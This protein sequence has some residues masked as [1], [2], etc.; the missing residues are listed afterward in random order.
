MDAF[1]MDAARLSREEI[2]YDLLRQHRSRNEKPAGAESSLR[3]ADSLTPSEKS[4]S[5]AIPVGAAPADLSGVLSGDDFVTDDKSTKPKST[6]PRPALESEHELVDST[7]LPDGVTIVDDATRTVGSRFILWGPADDFIGQGWRTLEITLGL[8][9][10]VSIR[11]NWK[12]IDVARDTLLT[13]SCIV[14]I[15]ELKRTLKINPR[16]E[17]LDNPTWSE[18][19]DFRLGGIEQKTL[20]NRPYQIKWDTVTK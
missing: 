13:G 16:E 15:P 20:S 7:L 2:E 10:E 6:A 12:R 11:D 4:M 8:G 1:Y 19:R 9:E 3:T 18:G 17:P 14:E 5:G